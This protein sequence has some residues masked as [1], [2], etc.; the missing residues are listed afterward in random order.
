MHNNRMSAFTS[1]CHV[2]FSH[3]LKRKASD[4]VLSVLTSHVITFIHTLTTASCCITPRF[5]NLCLI[6][7]SWAK[8]KARGIGDVYSFGKLKL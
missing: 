3:A 2:M 7:E 6:N 8:N 4:F 5:L 1:L